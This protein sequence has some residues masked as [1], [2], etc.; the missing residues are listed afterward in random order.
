MKEWIRNIVV[1][2]LFGGFVELLL[3]SNSM[4]RFL[5]VVVGLFVLTMLLEPVT[6]LVNKV[7]EGSAFDLPA[8]A[9]NGT[10]QVLKS[11]QELAE[12]QRMKVLE[13]YRRNVAR[14]IASLV[15]LSGQEKVLEVRVEVEEAPEK[16]D[17]G[18][19]KSLK[20]ILEH[21]RDGEL[22]AA[23]RFARLLADFYGLP[24]DAVRVEIRHK[25]G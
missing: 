8:V 11:G 16:P 23:E 22:P 17:F 2:V 20:V 15:E 3:P 9:E 12:R 10:A 24:K 7:E 25:G 13:E 4:K 21:A 18:R 5:Q 19:L 1:L 6:L 14:Q